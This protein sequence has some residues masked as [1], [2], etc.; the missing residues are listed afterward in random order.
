MGAGRPRNIFGRHPVEFHAW[1]ANRQ[2]DTPLPKL[3]DEGNALGC[4]IS[5]PTVYVELTRSSFCPEAYWLELRLEN[6]S[7]FTPP[8]PVHRNDITDMLTQWGLFGLNW[9]EGNKLAQAC[10]QGRV[11]YAFLLRPG[12]YYYVALPNGWEGGEFSFL[13]DKGAHTASNLAFVVGS[14]LYEMAGVDCGELPDPSEKKSLRIAEHNGL[15]GK[16]VLAS[17]RFF[18]RAFLDGKFNPVSDVKALEAKLP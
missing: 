11:P 14:R 17:T 12:P 4:D 16:L 6:G 18:R 3:L 8:S 10:F 9:A 5:N 7:A 15:L 1:L 2:W 13:H